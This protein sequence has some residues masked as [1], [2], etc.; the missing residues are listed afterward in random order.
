VW[1]ELALPPADVAAVLVDAETRFFIADGLK[2]TAASGTHTVRPPC[3]CLRH[4]P[5]AAAGGQ[6]L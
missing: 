6:R 3:D 2:T 5:A 1:A 4:S